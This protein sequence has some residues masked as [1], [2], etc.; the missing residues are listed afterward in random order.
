M[1][2]RS[3]GINPAVGEIAGISEEDF[4]FQNKKMIE[5]SQLAS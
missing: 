3:Q 5:F 4:V 1:K 2:K